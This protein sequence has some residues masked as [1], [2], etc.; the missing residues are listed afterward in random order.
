MIKEEDNWG[1]YDLRGPRNYDSASPEYGGDG[2]T[3]LPEDD[4]I[5][6]IIYGEEDNTLPLPSAEEYDLGSVGGGS[7]GKQGYPQWDLKP[8]VPDRST[9]KPNTDSS[10]AD[11][12][13]KNDRSRGLPLPPLPMDESSSENDDDELGNYDNVGDL[14]AGNF[15]AYDDVDDED[16]DYD[17]DKEDY[18]EELDLGLALTTANN[19][20]LLPEDSEAE[21]ESYQAMTHIQLEIAPES[22]FDSDEFM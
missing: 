20:G 14:A 19:T 18:E 1:A 4:M 22:D 3:P 11:A 8:P 5:P 12:N 15:A 7:V 16:E 21:E 2:N 17:D 13:K 9:T 10:Q 6:D